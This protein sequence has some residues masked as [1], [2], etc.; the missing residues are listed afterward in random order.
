MN[1]NTK[2]MLKFKTKTKNCDD[3]VDNFHTNF[4]KRITFLHPTGVCGW[5]FHR[6]GGSAANMA[7]CLYLSMNTFLCLICSKVEDSEMCLN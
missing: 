5:T 2:D 1:K 7:V 6:T 4:L 3:F